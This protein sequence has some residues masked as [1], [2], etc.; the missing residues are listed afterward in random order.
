MLYT[1]SQVSCE[2]SI[3]LMEQ[4]T[5]YHEY[6]LSALSAALKLTPGYFVTREHGEQAYPILHEQLAAVPPRSALVLQF[7]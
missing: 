2:H 3:T 1:C 7:P 6:S 4:T 5:P